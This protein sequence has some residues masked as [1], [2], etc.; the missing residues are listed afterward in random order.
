MLLRKRET[1]HLWICSGTGADLAPDTW[2]GI[3]PSRCWDLHRWR[4][5]AVW[6]ARSD[7]TENRRQGKKPWWVAEPEESGAGET[8]WRTA[9]KSTTNPLSVSGRCR[10]RGRGEDATDA[11]RTGITED[12]CRFPSRRSPSKSRNPQ[13]KILACWQHCVSSPTKTRRASKSFS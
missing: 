8:R 9:G 6:I 10:R 12:C 2:L 13:E 1:T 7:S 3:T 4:W 5:S 11:R